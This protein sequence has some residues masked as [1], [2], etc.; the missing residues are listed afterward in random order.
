[1]TV[2]L[3]FEALDTSALQSLGGS[4]NRVLRRVEQFFN[5][6]LLGQ[7]GNWQIEGEYAQAASLAMQRL[8]QQLTQE[9]ECTAGYAE[10]NLTDIDVEGVLRDIGRGQAKDEAAALEQT[11]VA[12]VLVAG[13]RRVS[14]KTANQRAYLNAIRNNTL[15]LAVGPA[16]SGKT[17]LAVAAA[18]AA[19][20]SN[21][22]ERII[23][24]RP[25]VEAGER[26]GFLPGDLQQKVDPYLRPLFDALSDMLGIEKMN[27][28]IE[29]NRI[30]IAPL[31][32]M[33][34][35]TLSDA[36]I[37]LDEAQNTTRE[38]MKMFLTRLGFG[39]KM[40]VTGDVTQVDL[41]HHHQ[42]GLLHALQVLEHVTDIGICRL[43]GCDVV[44]HRLVE[45]IVNA[46]E[47]R[48]ASTSHD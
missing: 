44:R 9:A 38:Q 4:E 31:A 8:L 47:D 16:G 33:R 1:M 12:D 11:D 6:R 25:A 37:I 13:R 43:A 39:A 19:M 34:G 26:L 36:F 41:P 42:S 48:E 2:S 24:T 27:A 15:T 35:R 22:A 17:Y 5:V 28:L 32:Y 21:R 46:Y 18:V 23:L 45:Y 29:Q 20:N 30:E 14:G 10:V 3:R 7:P 40:V